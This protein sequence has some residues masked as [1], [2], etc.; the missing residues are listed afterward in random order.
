MTKTHNWKGYLYA[1][2]GAVSISNVYIFSKAA[3]LELDL[4]VFLFYWFL[5]GLL[6]FA[7]Y[8]WWR[9]QLREVFGQSRQQYRTVGKI[10]LFEVLTTGLFFYS[11]DVI[12]NPSLVSFMGNI[13]PVWVAVLGFLM[14]GERYT[15]AE[16]GAMLLVLVGV[17]ALSYRPGTHLADMFVPGAQWVLLSSLL[18]AFSTVYTKKGVAS[19][20]PVLM[21]L[22]RVVVLFVATALAVVVAGRSLAI[23]GTAL[24]HTAMGSFLG[25]F[26]AVS[27]NYSAMQTLPASLYS[28]INSTKSF[29]V[30][31]GAFLFFQILPTGYQLLGGVLSVL[32][33]VALVLAKR[34]KTKAAQGYQGPR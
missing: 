5:L 6:W 1:V 24:F 9:G 18:G 12:D 29:F 8:L 33:L 28:I 22:G 23:S 2:L 31:L 32:G 16:L 30:V 11:I 10:G 15:W 26:L 4:L 21:S 17:L 20:R 13:G 14:L 25:P 19:V 3:L 34:H 7:G 27:F